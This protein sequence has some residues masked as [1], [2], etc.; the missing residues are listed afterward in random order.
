MDSSLQRLSEAVENG[1]KTKHVENSLEIPHS[2][3]DKFYHDVEF[4]EYGTLVLYGYC[5]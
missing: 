2:Y 5:S 4:T 1:V 3:R